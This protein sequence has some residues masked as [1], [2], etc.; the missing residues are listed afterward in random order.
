MPLFVFLKNLTVW[1]IVV[2][3]CNQRDNPLVQHQYF[4][5]CFSKMIREYIGTK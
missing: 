5:D 2:E 4:L 3:T 1:P